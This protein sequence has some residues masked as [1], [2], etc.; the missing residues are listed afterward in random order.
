[1]A[2]TPMLK[3]IPRN[4]KFLAPFAD[5]AGLACEA[6]AE[7]KE[8]FPRDDHVADRVQRIK[9]FAHRGGKI[10]PDTLQPPPTTILTPLD[11]EDIHT[12]ATDLDD[13]LD[14]MDNAAHHVIDYG[15][16]EGVFGA[17]ELAEVLEKQV[18][19]IRDAMR[20]LGANEAVLPYSVEINRLENE[21]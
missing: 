12:L 5:M 1:R 13:I 11:P 16:G 4:E 2:G 7:L 9:D 18:H 17:S 8:L 14:M 19:Q 3:L 15:V 6:A 20:H 10:T 21:A